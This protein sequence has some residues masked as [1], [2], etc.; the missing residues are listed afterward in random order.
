MTNKICYSHKIKCNTKLIETNWIHESKIMHK[1]H[2][3]SRAPTTKMYRNFE[4]IPISENE[5][6]LG[7]WILMLM[8]SMLWNNHSSPDDNLFDACHV[9]SYVQWLRQLQKCIIHCLS[10]K[11]ENF[12]AQKTSCSWQ[13]TLICSIYKIII[14]IKS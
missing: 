13:T 14:I 4:N 6:N 8:L 11:M 5:T 12:N 9:I 1:N 10:F 7:S 3:F 2:P